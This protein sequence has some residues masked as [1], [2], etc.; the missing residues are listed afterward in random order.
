MAYRFFIPLIIV[1]IVSCGDKNET[2]KLRFLTRGNAAYNNNDLEEALRFYDEAIGKDSLFVDAWNNKGLALMKQQQYDAAIYCFDRAI[3]YKPS[4][5]GAILNNAKANL[6]VHQYYG[7]LDLLNQLNKV[8]PDTSLLF[9]TKGLVHAEMGEKEAALGDFRM[10]YRA[11]TNNAEPLVNMANI[12][13][14]HHQ[15]DSARLYLK[16]ALQLDAS[17]PVAYNILAM[18]YADQEKYD[19][20]LVAIDTAI[21]YKKD[22]AYFINNRGY[23]LLKLGR[24][25][26]AEEAIVQSMKLDPY[27]GWVYRNLGLVRYAQQDYKEAVRLLSRAMKM[28]ESI[29][30]IYLDLAGAYYKNGQADQ[31]CDLFAKAPMTSQIIKMKNKWCE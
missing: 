30:N 12:Y 29:E 6:A 22:D 14:H 7:A 20:A 13:Y 5:G 1:F 21:S 2:D 23:I 28:D 17:Q 10:A 27:N 16:Q 19:E 9:F 8:W 25:Q 26:E 18:I 4:Y 15:N 24:L 3:E 31:A 11:D